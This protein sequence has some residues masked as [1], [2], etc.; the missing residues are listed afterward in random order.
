MSLKKKFAECKL[1]DME[2][3]PEVWVRKLEHLQL[4][5]RGVNANNV[6]TD[7][8]MM[9]HILANLPGEYSELMITTVES[10]LDCDGGE[11]F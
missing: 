2:S 11:K 4:R 1:E 9:A 10:E 8:D 3:N 5:I 7:K 6:L